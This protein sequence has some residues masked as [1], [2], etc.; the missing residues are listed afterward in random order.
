MMLHRVLA[1]VVASKLMLNEGTA[2]FFRFLWCPFA[3]MPFPI[4]PY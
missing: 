3:S 1:V 4:S 2:F